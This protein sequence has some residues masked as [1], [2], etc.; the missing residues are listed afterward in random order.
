MDFIHAVWTPAGPGPY[1]TLIALHG[2]GAHCQDLAPLAPMLANGRLQVVCPQ[3][4]FPL[5]GA[6]YSYAPMFTWM[7]RGADDRPLD[8]EVERVATALSSFIDEICERYDA[9]TER[10]ALMGFSQGGFLAYRLALSEPHRWQGAAMLSTWLSDD[11]ADDVH[12]DA[13]DLPLLVQHGTN[14]PLVG[15]D[16]GRSSRDR[17][18]AMRMNLDYREYPMQHEIGRQSMHDLSVWLTDRLLSERSAD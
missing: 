9:D 2:H 11:A 16:R 17:L 3:A 1:P 14:D 4:E 5:E 18:Q 8:G 7:K 12:P 10:L 13:A 6:P 15:V